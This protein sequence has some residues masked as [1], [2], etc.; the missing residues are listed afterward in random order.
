MVAIRANA[1]RYLP[2]SLDAV[3]VKGAVDADN[4]DALHER[5]RNEEPVEWVPMMHRKRSD[6]NEIFAGDWQNGEPIASK[7]FTNKFVKGNAKLEFAKS[8]LD[9]EFPERRNTHNTLVVHI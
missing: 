3:S 9:C 8:N 6:R 4:R 7:P 2:D 5:L 1:E